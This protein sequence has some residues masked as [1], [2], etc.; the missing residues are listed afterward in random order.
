MRLGQTGDRDAYESLLRELLQSL[1]RVVGRQW[2]RAEDVE[3][4]VQEILISL[5]GVRHTYDPER[6]FIPWFMAIVRRRIADAARRSASR[7]MHEMNVEILP[8]TSADEDA[9]KKTEG[10][11]AGEAAD[12]VRHAL[13]SLPP[14]QRE[15]VELL[16][17]QGLSLKEASKKTGRS[18][19][20]LKVMV[21]RAM[22]SMR[23]TLE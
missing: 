13:S 6:P 22:K 5:H 10:N 12:Q 21:H 3:D 9:K 11:T 18:V 20:A 19:P 15:A 14:A 23:R 16:K 8:E 17:V 7:R 4:I 1:R 2:H